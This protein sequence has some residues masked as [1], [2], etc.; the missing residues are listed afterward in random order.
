MNFIMEKIKY[1]SLIVVLAWS[2]S[3]CKEWLDVNENPDYPT[4]EVA[5][6]SSRLPWIQHHY[7]YAYGA[8]STRA[9]MITGTISSRLFTGN[10]GLLPA[11]NPTNSA[12][13]TPY[14]HWFVGSAANLE[15][16]RVKAEAE[17]A[18]HYLGAAYTIRAMGFMLMVDWYGEMPYEE[19]LSS[20]LTPAYS[21]GKT[22]FEGCLAD[23]ETALEYFQMTQ[24]SSATPLS[25]GDS[26]NNGDVQKW[27]RLVYGL[28]AR[29]LNNL[30]KKQEY[31]P[32]AVLA[33]LSNA[34]QS[35]AEGTIINH[36]NDPSDMT[37][38]VLIGDPLKTS[39][40]FN[41][42]AWSD[43]ARF[44]RWYVDLL[45]NTFPGGSGIEDPRASKML[46]SNQHWDRTNGVYTPRFIRTKGVDAIHSN[47]RLQNGPIISNYTTGSKSYSVNSTDPARKGDT[48]YVNIRALCG[49]TGATT[50]ESTYTDADGTILST[51][52]FYTRP[53]SPTDVITYHEMCFIKA[54]VLFRKGD[55]GGALAA[56]Q[57]GIRAHMEQMNSKLREYA[58]SVNPGK[59]PMD[60]TVVE[61]FLGS[62]AVA[63]NVS[64]LT[65]SKIM[66]QKYIAMS[67]TQQNWNDMRR[68][69]FSAGNIGDFGVVYTDFDRPMEFSSD[70]ARKMPGAS[71]NEVNYWFRRMMQCSHE[72]N[73]NSA[74]MEASNPK[75]FAD[76][77]WSVPVWWDEEN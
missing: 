64:E 74:N 62:A 70:A 33:A 57:E 36:V 9:A 50:E 24:P 1:I 54:E 71:K 31:D 8:A 43:W 48:I 3:S 26:W 11:W 12:S 27:I 42:A 17:E 45:E 65:M 52:T 66:Q 51:G 23:L 25:E 67:F 29:W 22:I 59:Q 30:S 10:N 46:P 20:V 49:M 37:G 19:A 55:K 76:D 28:K 7:G 56:Y 58:G 60:E 18:W 4:N 15:D 53:E 75:A 77:I 69:N 41:T 16:L 44:T 40:I 14:Q 47:I 35:N 13:V 39:Y 68:F 21:D 61:D 34:P 5:A 6:V 63:Q 72:V 38:D 2:F 32:D 73:Y